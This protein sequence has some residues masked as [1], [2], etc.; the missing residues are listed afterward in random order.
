MLNIGSDL[1]DYRLNDWWPPVAGSMMMGPNTYENI[2]N[3]QRTKFGVFSEWQAN[4]T[5]KLSS[6]FGVRMETVWANTG[7]VQ[8]YS[9]GGMSMMNGDVAAAKAFN[10]MNRARTDVNV[11]L[12]AMLQY[13][14][15][16][17]IDLGFGY[18]RAARS[19]NLYERY[20]W[21][22]DTMARSMIGWFGDANLYVGNPNLKPEI[23]NTV[24]GTIGW[25][26]PAKEIWDVK[27]TPYYTYVQDFI[28]VT[29]IGN[30]V[31]GGTTF[32]ELEFMNRDAQLYG[33]DLSG[34]LRVLDNAKYGMATVNGVLNW[35]QGNYIDTGNSLYHMMPL[36]ADLGVEH[37]I[38]GWTSDVDLRLVA[39]KT[40]VDSD[41]NEPTTPGFAVL[42]MGT[43][44]SWSRYQVSF[45]A[46]NL[47]NQ[48]YYEP[49][50]GVDY[51][52]WKAGG[53]KGEIG[54]LPAPGRSLIV[55]LTMR[56]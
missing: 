43:S 31:Q 54:A 4:W 18:G 7:Q 8:P 41:R 37:R 53:N 38:G 35:V 2:H 50:G 15:T 1:D 36:N 20:S 45:R 28:G 26:D 11:D 46:E 5:P 19:P 12:T 27:L 49:L 29:R 52:D 33:I 6:L 10:A 24:S 30:F 40:L 44:Y 56:L 14:P 51:A 3:G 25:H 39:A 48:Q 9:W 17:Q 47:L 23:A 32:A 21:G 22:A 55:G 42:N 34:K 13:H 16:D